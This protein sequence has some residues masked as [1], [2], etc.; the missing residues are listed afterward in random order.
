[1]KKIED[2]L[3]KKFKRRSADTVYTLTESDKE[4]C[5]L[6]SWIGDGGHKY[7]I[8]YSIDAIGYF[9]QGAWVL[10]EEDKGKHVTTLTL[11]D[12]YNEK[13]NYVG[14]KGVE[15]VSRVFDTGASRNSDEGK[16]DF[17]GFLSP[18]VL[19]AYAEYM[20]KNTFLEDGTRRDSDNWQKGIPVPAYMKSMYRHFFDVWSNYRGL[21]TPETQVQNLCGLLFNTMGMLHEI[22][23]EEVK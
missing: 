17:E 1:M 6:V 7:S 3:G 8:D 20:H 11:E 2:Y 10:I 13:N 9:E 23:K 22:L 14:K 12:M 19:K 15:S 16:L 21:E 5:I 18:I 4:G